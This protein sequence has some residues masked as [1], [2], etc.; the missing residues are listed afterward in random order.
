MCGRRSRDLAAPRTHAPRARLPSAPV[1][2]SKGVAA[3]HGAVVS[4]QHTC[5]DCGR[6]VQRIGYIGRSPTCS[7]CMAQGP[8]RVTLYVSGGQ[9]WINGTG[10]GK[11]VEY[12]RADLPSPCV[13]L[14]LRPG[15][16]RK[17]KMNGPCRKNFV[18]AKPCGPSPDG[19][20][21]SCAC[22]CAADDVYCQSLTPEEER[23]APANLPP[24]TKE[25]R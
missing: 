4:Q 9:V 14:R 16:N 10:G 15:H 6:S 17:E 23:L 22:G 12:I 13:P 24:M 3:G 2:D 21:M 11:P 18:H 8:K 1:G 7:P 5:S 20:P 19:D 25:G